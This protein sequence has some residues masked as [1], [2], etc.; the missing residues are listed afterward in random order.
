MT[1][2]A[3]LFTLAA[4]GISETVYL[5]RKRMAQEKPVCIMGEDCSKVLESRYNK[6]LGINNEFLGLAFYIAISFFTAFLVIG[7]EPMILWEMLVRALIAFGVVISIILIYLQW[8]VIKAWCFW[9]VMSAVTV[10]IMGII[11]L[12]T[13]LIL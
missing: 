7:I 4:I 9:C 5:I 10:F 1:P 6:V 2:H 13:E 8:R 12:T 3:L 11:V